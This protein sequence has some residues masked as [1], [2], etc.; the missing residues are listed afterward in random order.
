M[1]LAVASCDG[2]PAQCRGAIAISAF[3]DT[4][5]VLKPDGS[6]WT[7]TQYQDGIQPKLALAH[8]GAVGFANQQMCLR[9]VDGSVSC[10]FLEIG[11]P[12]PTDAQEVSIWIAGGLSSEGFNTCAILPNSDLTC[13]LGGAFTTLTTGIRRVSAAFSHYCAVTTGGLLDC[14]TWPT[15]IASQSWGTA[16]TSPT[17]VVEVQSATESELSIARTA[18]GAVW[19]LTNVGTTQIQGIDGPV[20]QLATG[21]FLRCA[22]V[23]DGRVFCWDPG[24]LLDPVTPD[25]GSE[26][27]QQITTMPGPAIAITAGP[28]LGGGEFACALLQDTT[29]WCWGAGFEGLAGMRIGSCG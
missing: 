6:V 13:Y 14:E 27:P 1:S 18:T 15:T 4:I 2:S 17:D 5:A 3:G 22:L 20:V 26:S 7:W 29:V 8:S 11:P 10:P 9:L 21:A 24:Q 23:M 25:G 12:P 19:E 16:V 28:G